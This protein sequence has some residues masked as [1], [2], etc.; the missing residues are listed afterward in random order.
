MDERIEV[1]E[2]Y[3]SVMDYGKRPGCFIVCS[4]YSV[5]SLSRVSWRVMV[6]RLS[7]IKTI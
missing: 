2:A 7:G 4:I 5:L 6:Q 1:G 3:M